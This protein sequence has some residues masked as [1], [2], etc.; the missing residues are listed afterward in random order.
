M[1]GQRDDP[2]TW[3][4]LK[5]LTGNRSEGYWDVYFPKDPSGYLKS[6]GIAAHDS[7]YNLKKTSLY[8]RLRDD[9]GLEKF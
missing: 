4:D 9:A 6:G 5:N 2:V 8:R 1:Y 3:F 7:K